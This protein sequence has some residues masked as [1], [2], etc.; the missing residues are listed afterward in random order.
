MDINFYKPII[1]FEYFITSCKN[2][3]LSDV[4]ES[5]LTLTMIES[6]TNK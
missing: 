1:D 5:L 6:K 4:K 3:V 2:G